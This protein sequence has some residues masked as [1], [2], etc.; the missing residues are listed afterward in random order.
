MAD[1][2]LSNPI[3]FVTGP[4]GCGKS[5]FATR[6][7]IQYLA[8]GKVVCTNYDL[9]GDW[10]ETA[11]NMS[12]SRR[13]SWSDEARYEWMMECRERA[14]RY[15]AQDDLYNYKLPGE[16]EDRGLLVLDEGGLQMNT[17][18]AGQRQKAERERYETGIKSVEFYINMRKLGFSALVLAHHQDML[19]NQL[20]MMG[21]QVIR[22]RNL[23]RIKLPFIGLPMSR[24][25]KFV[26]IHIMNE[27]KPPMITKRELYGLDMKIAQHYRSMETFVATPEVGQGLRPQAPAKRKLATQPSQPYYTWD[28]GAARRRREPKSV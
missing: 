7:V 12:W 20:R 22:L 14:F 18:E 3:N 19:D 8:A 6:Y 27:T 1:N 13:K 15:D 26:A 4:L 23:A 10:W 5:Y 21:G 25:A 9:H 24:K 28:Q 16:G 11:C 17:R 2:I